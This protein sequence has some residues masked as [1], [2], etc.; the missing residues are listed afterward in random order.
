M[1]CDDV[2]D[3]GDLLDRIAGRDATAFALLYDRHSKA[4]YALAYHLLG[5]PDTAQDVVQDAFLSVWLRPIARHQLQ[6]TARVWLLA[7]VRHRAIDYLR[8]RIYRTDH[9][10]PWDDMMLLP[11][12]ADTWERACQ[13]V[14]RIHVHAALRRLPSDQQG[15]LMLSYFEGRTHDEIARLLGVPLGTVKG[16]LRAGLR[17]MRRYLYMH[18]DAPDEATA[19]SPLNQGRPYL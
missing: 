4:A 1:N 3:D 10:C 17:K 9:Q 12:A 16:R 7:V 8:R 18:L 2:P 14:E 11:D 5:D 6:F 13:R 15:V 19:L